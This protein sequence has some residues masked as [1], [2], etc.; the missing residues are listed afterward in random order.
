VAA[1]AD[2]EAPDA[3]DAATDSTEVAAAEAEAKIEVMALFTG[4]VAVLTALTIEELTLAALKLAAMDEATE[5][6]TVVATPLKVVVTRPEVE[7]EEA[8]DTAARRRAVVMNCIV[9]WV[10]HALSAM[11]L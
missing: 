11:M 6:G 1:L 10:V 2:W 4:A 8:D 9:S 5:A 7:A 3:R